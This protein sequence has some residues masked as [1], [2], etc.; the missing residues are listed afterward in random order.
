MGLVRGFPAGAGYDVRGNLHD[1]SREPRQVAVGSAGAPGERVL[2]ATRPPDTALQVRRSGFSLEPHA[3]I[4][5]KPITG[6]RGVNAESRCA[7]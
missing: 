3:M 6:R 7:E 4:A 1:G 5:P 2:G